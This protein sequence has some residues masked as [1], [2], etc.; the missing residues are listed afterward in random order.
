MKDTG[1]ITDK[2]KN[3]ATSERKSLDLTR[4]AAKPEDKLIPDS[5]R[6]FLPG[7]S[8]KGESS[9]NQEKE[10]EKETI[11]QHECNIRTI[12]RL[13]EQ[14]EDKYKAMTWKLAQDLKKYEESKKK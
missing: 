8:D 11:Q 4:V 7:G 1:K 3:P 12:H 5:T 10:K 13:T 2:G 6:R 14:S 9:K